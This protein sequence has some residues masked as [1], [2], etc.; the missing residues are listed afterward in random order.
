MHPALCLISTL[1]SGDRALRE[2]DPNHVPRIGQVTFTDNHRAVINPDVIDEK[3]MSKIAVL[4]SRSAVANVWLGDGTETVDAVS[5]VA[6]L[7]G[8]PRERQVWHGPEGLRENPIAQK[9]SHESR[10]QAEWRGLI[11]AEMS[12]QEKAKKLFEVRNRHDVAAKGLQP[13]DPGYLKSEEL[14]VAYY[15]VVSDDSSKWNAPQLEYRSHSNSTCIYTT[16][17]PWKETSRR[18][19]E[20]LRCEVEYQRDGWATWREIIVPDFAVDPAH[21][22]EVKLHGL[23]KGA[24][25]HLRARCVYHL[26]GHGE[27]ETVWQSTTF[28]HGTQKPPEVT[29]QPGTKVIL[30]NKGYRT[31]EEVDRIVGD[32]CS[33]V[34]CEGLQPIKRLRALD[35]SRVKAPAA[36]QPP[37]PAQPAAPAPAPIAP[38]QPP[39]PV[40]PALPAKAPALPP[41]PAMDDEDEDDDRTENYVVF[42]CPITQCPCVDPVKTADGTIYE[43]EAIEHWLLEL[44]HDTSPATGVRLQNNILTEVDPA[45]S[46]EPP[47]RRRTAELYRAQLMHW[48]TNIGLPNGGTVDLSRYHAAFVNEGLDSIAMVKAN[49]NGDVLARLVTPPFHRKTF[50]EAIQREG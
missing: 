4:D 34:N 50:E 20:L 25:Y 22:A 6:D 9:P 39:P 17:S 32:K 43:R 16:K 2:F 18:S 23:Q 5:I 19:G 8:I 28:T 15:T 33:L 48:M 37:R 13:S 21:L 11:T 26:I 42:T 41:V 38:A 49:L 27:Q 10:I 12:G 24:L 31:E 30:H 7:T 47:R 14:R 36:V 40:A 1:N 45:R 44:G 3:A 46:P 29:L 35:G